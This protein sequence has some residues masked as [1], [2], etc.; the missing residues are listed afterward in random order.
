MKHLIFLLNFMLLFVATSVAGAPKCIQARVGESYTLALKQVLKF[1]SLK[2]RAVNIIQDSRCPEDAQCIIKGNAKVAL[3]AGKKKFELLD[4]NKKLLAN[5]F[6]LLL[7]D[8]KPYPK[9][10]EK[11]DTEAYSVVLQLCSAK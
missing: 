2:I 9:L 6:S 10:G 7:V 1:G 3:Q 4:G 5:G 11:P 8:V